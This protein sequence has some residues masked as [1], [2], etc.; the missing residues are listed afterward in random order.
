MLPG[1]EH[2][3]GQKSIPKKSE[4]PA[5]K[6]PSDWQCLPTSSPPR[7]PLVTLH[8]LLLPLPP[9]LLLFSL[10]PASVV[11]L[12]WLIIRD[13]KILLSSF[14]STE[15][16]HFLARASVAGPL[17]GDTLLFIAPFP[18]QKRGAWEGIFREVY[19]HT[20]THTHSHTLK[21]CSH[22]STNPPTLSQKVTYT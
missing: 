21:L 11:C 19:R 7:P 10:W 22:T 15:M 17:P 13:T 6:A 9:H 16:S 1:S 20:H 14:L 5:A 18:P 2:R 12:G 4:I 8:P 3:E